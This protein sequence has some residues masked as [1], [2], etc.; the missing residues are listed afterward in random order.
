MREIKFRG[1]GKYCEYKDKWIYGY[2]YVYGEPKIYSILNENDIVRVNVFGSFVPAFIN[3]DSN[4]IGQYTGLKDKNG[5]E[6]Y[7]GDII[8][9]TVIDNGF[10]KFISVVGYKDGGFILKEEW[11]Y[12]PFHDLCNSVYE[13]IGN[14][15]DNPELL[16]G[17]SDDK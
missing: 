5:I 17:D 11:G 14:I 2:L 9:R 15:H 12:A 7:E 16:L 13:V 10:G 8:E 3:V 1:K 6:I 4:T